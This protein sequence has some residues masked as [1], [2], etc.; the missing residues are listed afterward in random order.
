MFE[1]SMW[2]NPLTD[3]VHIAQF[4]MEIMRLTDYF[5]AETNSPPQQRGLAEDQ[6]WRLAKSAEW[7][8]GFMPIE[9]PST[10]PDI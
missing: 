3:R 10:M 1:G 6:A 5:P 2:I 9:Y 8:R 7:W 4:A